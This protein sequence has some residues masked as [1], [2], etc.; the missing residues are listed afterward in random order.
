[1]GNLLRIIERIYESAA[2]PSTR[3]ALAA[4]IAHEFGAE[5]SFIY[6]AED[7][8]ARHR[9]VNKDLLSAT[10]NFDQWAHVSYTNYYLERCEWARRAAGQRF[11]AALIGDDVLTADELGNSEIYTDY[12]RKI[13]VFHALGGLFPVRGADVGMVAIHRPRSAAEFGLRERKLMMQLLPHFQRLFQIHQRLEAVERG[14][15]LTTEV[16]ERLSLGAL[17]VD[18]NARVMFANTLAVRQLRTGR[19]LTLVGGCLRAQRPDEQ[20]ALSGLIHAAALTAVGQEGS[21]G[22]LTAISRSSGTSLSVLVSPFRG[23]AGTRPDQHSVL[24]LISD[25]GSRAPIPERVIAE[26]FKLTVAEARLLAALTAGKTM[27]EYAA[28]AGVT[29]NTAKTQLRQ[30]FFKT[31]YNRQADIIRAVLADPLIAIHSSGALSG[32]RGAAE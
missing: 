1:M 18:G 9:L 10:A 11:P 4:Q 19:G 6:T 22:G 2:D 24:V 31:G 13:G 21:A 29:M 28:A 5:S 14:R 15:T 20:A 32:V 7:S 3:G 26:S 27:T 16:L 23:V 30:I 17:L 8:R 25:P 12:Y